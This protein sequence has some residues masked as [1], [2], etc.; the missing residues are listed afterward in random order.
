MSNRAY[1]FPTG[2]IIDGLIVYRSENSPRSRRIA[3]SRRFRFFSPKPTER[4]ATDRLLELLEG[5]YSSALAPGW[6]ASFHIHHME[7]APSSM[8]GEREQFLP[9]QVD[10]D[11]GPQNEEGKRVGAEQVA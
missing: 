8:R 7:S 10:L 6:T 3:D 5:L 11:Q 4:R 9:V 1:I 2:V